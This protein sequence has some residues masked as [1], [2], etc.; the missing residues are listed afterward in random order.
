MT[1]QAETHIGL[2]TD[3][4]PLRTACGSVA[5]KLPARA[6]LGTFASPSENP[7]RRPRSIPAG[8]P[9]K[10]ETSCGRLR[11]PC[12]ASV[13]A[14]VGLPAVVRRRRFPAP[15]RS[16]PAEPRDL[17]TLLQREALLAMSVTIYIAL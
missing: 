5:W 16:W 11:H 10:P 4:S 2:Q 14:C 13:A 3:G 17:L 9:G 15:S 7:A 8:A 6:A 1:N 12:A